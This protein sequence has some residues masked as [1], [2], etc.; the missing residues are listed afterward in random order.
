[1]LDDKFNVIAITLQF[2]S[3]KML[4]QLFMHV[5]RDLLLKFCKHH[6]ILLSHDKIIV[7]LTCI[8]YIIFVTNHL[9]CVTNRTPHF[10]LEK[11]PIQPCHIMGFYMD[12]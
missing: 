1:M 5:D 12:T 6:G 7:M 9:L 8:L 11:P 4:I 2:F 3:F 10:L